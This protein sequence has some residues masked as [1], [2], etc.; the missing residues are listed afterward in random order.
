FLI[1]FSLKECPESANCLGA[2]VR[3]IAR[4]TNDIVFTAKESFSLT[5][6]VANW[7]HQKHKLPRV[8]GSRENPYSDYREAANYMVGRLSCIAK[9]MMPDDDTMHILVARTKNT[10]SDVAL[11]FSETVS[12]Y[13]LEQV[14]VSEWLPVVIS[15]GDRFELDIYRGEHRELFETANLVLA[16]DVKDAEKGN[17][18]LKAH[19]LAL[20]SMEII[21]DGKRRTLGA[22]MAMPYCVSSGY[23][24]SG[25]FGKTIS[26]TGVGICNRTLDSAIWRESAKKAAELDAKKNLAKKVREK[27]HGTEIACQQ[28]LDRNRVESTVHA[29]I[30]GARVVRERYDEKTCKAVVKLEVEQGNVFSLLEKSLYD[31]RTSLAVTTLVKSIKKRVSQPSYRQVQSTQRTGNA[32]V[33]YQRAQSAMLRDLESNIRG[34]L[35]QYEISPAVVNLI[36]ITGSLDLPDCRKENHYLS[37]ESVPSRHYCSLNYDLKLVMR[38][39]ELFCCRSRV[40]GMG[41]N[42]NTAWEDALLG[43]VDNLYPLVSDVALAVSEKKTLKDLRKT[44]LSLDESLWQVSDNFDVG[45]VL[46]FVERQIEDLR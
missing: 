35:L 40:R 5:G 19:L 4:E 32:R 6:N 30:S 24:S 27:I 12:F 7:Y 31:D 13:G 14:I 25:I 16:L 42:R 2:G 9:S 34:R 8:K 38:N 22:G 15:A 41:S 17:L 45:S 43:V 46:D 3:V 37:P 21:K 28:M 39:K 44:L 11:A 26:A 33:P 18:F 20:R 10:P 23:A 29:Y 1:E 36:S